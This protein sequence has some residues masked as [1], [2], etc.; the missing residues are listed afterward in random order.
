MDQ[1]E[2]AVVARLVEVVSQMAIELSFWVKEHG[3]V[4][5]AGHPDY[6]AA[7]QRFQPLL[8]QVGKAGDAG[9][10]GQTSSG[11]VLQ[12][13]LKQVEIQRRS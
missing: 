9:E 5:F 13:L 2:R 8:S 12:E 10:G 6:E 7:V 4:S 1:N 3:K 11:I